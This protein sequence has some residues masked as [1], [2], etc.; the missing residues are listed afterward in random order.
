MAPLCKESSCRG[1]CR[2]T[3]NNRCVEHRRVK[4]PLRNN[5]ELSAAT[6]IYPDAAAIPAPRPSFLTRT[7]ADLARHPRHA[8][9]IVTFAEHALAVVRC[10]GDATLAEITAGSGHAAE[11]G[12]TTSVHP[13]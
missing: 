3:A 5:D 9:T 4:L 10:A 1:A 6:A 12:A 8:A 13:D 11:F 2:T 7:P